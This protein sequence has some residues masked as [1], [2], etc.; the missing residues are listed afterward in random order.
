MRL[1]VVVVSWLALTFWFVTLPWAAPRVNALAGCTGLPWELECGSARPN[2][3]MAVW[4][5]PRV[6]CAQR[7]DDAR[8]AATPDAVFPAWCR[9]RGEGIFND[10]ACV[11]RRGTVVLRRFTVSYMIA[12]PSAIGQLSFLTFVPTIAFLEYVHT[13]WACVGAFFWCLILCFPVDQFF[14][15][16]HAVVILATVT[17]LWSMVE[18]SVRLRRR[19]SRATAVASSLTAVA[20]LSFLVFRLSRPAFVVRLHLVW[21]PYWIEVVLFS[22]I[23]AIPWAC[24]LADPETS[25]FE[26]YANNLV[27][28]RSSTALPGCATCSAK[29]LG[30]CWAASAATAAS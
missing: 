11:V 8:C 4:V 23:T 21:V 18:L 5:G 10:V 14:Y 25:P 30:P 12:T 20:V 3:D 2:L 6:R 1:S 7:L 16:H 26:G 15:V 17:L 9:L 27:A 13:P 22:C 29:G 24:A 19:R 28:K